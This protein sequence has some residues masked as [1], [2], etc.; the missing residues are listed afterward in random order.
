M[1]PEHYEPI[2]QSDSDNSFLY[3]VGAVCAWGPDPAGST[4]AG[5][6]EPASSQVSPVRDCRL[7]GRPWNHVCRGAGP[8]RHAQAPIDRRDEPKNG[9]N[10]GCLSSPLDLL[11]I[12]DPFTTRDCVESDCG[13]DQQLSC[14]CLSLFSRE[15]EGARGSRVRIG[16][17]RPPTP[18]YF[19]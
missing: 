15:G 11:R 3:R 2:Q 8:A 5:H 17:Q 9:G 4:S 16:L 14:G 6:D 19:V 10:Y 12:V 1:F 13:V 7:P 18:E